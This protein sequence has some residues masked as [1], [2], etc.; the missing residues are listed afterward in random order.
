MKKLLL[1]LIIFLL[2]SPLFSQDYPRKAIINSDTVAI[3]TINQVRVINERLV[4]LKEM[5]EEYY[6]V[7]EQLNLYRLANISLNKRINLMSDENKSL[8]KQVDN[9]RE[10]YII[11]DNMYRKERK[12]SFLIGGVA[13]TIGVAALI[14]LIAR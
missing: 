3:F 2:S 12:K 6:S 9:Y 13:V 8:T 10:L 7:T 14:T 11:H 5:N 1:F 4:D